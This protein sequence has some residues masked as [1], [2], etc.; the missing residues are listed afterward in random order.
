SVRRDWGGLLSPARGS[1]GPARPPR[2]SKTSK[3]DARRAMPM[4]SGVPPGANRI[5]PAPSVVRSGA[6]YFGMAVFGIALR[7]SLLF[8][9]RTARRSE[10]RT[11][12]ALCV[13]RHDERPDP[14]DA[15]G[16]KIFF[17]DQ[18]AARG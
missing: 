9:E 6:P 8:N 5:P 17:R 11:G 3:P 7:H 14:R 16:L 13:G 18:G 15:R 2:A 10:T 12:N 4:P 1:A